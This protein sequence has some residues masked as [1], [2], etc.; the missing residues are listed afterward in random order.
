MVCDTGS[1]S[2]AVSAISGSVVIAEV[3]LKP[4]TIPYTVESGTERKTVM[5]E[6]SKIEDTVIYN[7][8]VNGIPIK[9]DKEK[10]QAIRIL[11]L[12]HEHGAMPGKPED[13]D[14]QGQERLYKQDDWVD[15]LEDKEF[16]TVP[17]RPTPV[18]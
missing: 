8:H 16:I 10:V 1:Q 12:A 15:L 13:Y 9:V 11:T 4:D 5:V 17:N 2:L 6:A 14:L 3:R 7:V 18:A